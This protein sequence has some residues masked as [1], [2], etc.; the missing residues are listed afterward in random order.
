[1][2][3]KEASTEPQAPPQPPSEAPGEPITTL[4]R[5]SDGSVFSVR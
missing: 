4:T 3:A 1:M 2:A 5:E